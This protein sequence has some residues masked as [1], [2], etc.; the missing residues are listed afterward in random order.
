MPTPLTN[1]RWGYESNCYVCEQS[2]AGGMRVPFQLEDD[3]ETVTAAFTLD[4]TYSGAPALVHG[5]VSLALLDEA[6]A[7]ACIAVA[8]KWGL[9][10]STASTF[11]SPVFCDTPYRVEARVTAVSDVAVETVGT[12]RD[13]GGGAMIESSS[14]FHIVGEVDVATGQHE[15]DDRQRRLLGE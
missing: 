13:E 15:L 5:G 6:Q 12:I 7:W 10:A 8:G 3:A 11:L 2:N 1:D 14:S 4:R 9:T